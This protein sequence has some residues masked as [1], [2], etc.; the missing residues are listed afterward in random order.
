[1]A[2]RTFFQDVFERNGSADARH[3][4]LDGISHG[5]FKFRGNYLFFR[6]G[7]DRFDILRF[8]PRRGINRRAFFR[9]AR[10]QRLRGRGGFDSVFYSADYFDV[11]DKSVLESLIKDTK[12]IKVSMAKSNENKVKYI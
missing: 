8:R 3:H 7:F 6:Y 2:D 10:S 11:S 1:M 4:H 5:I 12:G 9:T